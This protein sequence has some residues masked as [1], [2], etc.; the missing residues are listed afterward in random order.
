[1]NESSNAALIC[2]LL[3]MLGVFL[4]AV[5]SN[6][7]AKGKEFVGE[8]FL[9]SRNFGV[10]AFAL[11]FAATNASG[12]TFMGFPALIYSHGWTLALWIAG[13]LVVPLVSMAMMGKRLNQVARKSGALTIPEVLRERFGSATVGL[14][15]TGLLIFFMFF[16]LVAQF[17]A[18]GKILSTLL[19]N[20]TLFQQ[21]VAG[22]ASGTAAI[23]WINQAEPDYLVCLIVFSIAVIFY[24]VY[25]GFRA[26]VWT[27]VMQ[28]IVMF[29]GV[30]LMLGLAIWQVGGMT[31][32]TQQMAAMTTPEHG[33]AI[34]TSET[35]ETKDRI[36]PKRSWIEDRGTVVRL[37]E[38]AEIPEGQTRSNQVA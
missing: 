23:P 38:I 13:Y 11:T 14:I 34:I 36:I 4:L 31:N 15:S 7:V 33:T 27:D 19:S 6:R 9:G 26:V 10:W 21:T 16:Y 30:L 35:I 8:Y 20:E 2:F 18:G 17:K 3:Y 32:A 24:V 37:A 5:L 1:M 22:V 28:G 25:G 29:V 12:G